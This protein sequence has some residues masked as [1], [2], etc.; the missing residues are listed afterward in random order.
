MP[1][2]MGGSVAAHRAE[3]TRRLFAS[4]RELLA[5]RGYDAITLADIAEHAG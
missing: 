1:R 5:E 4:L 3:Q 2:V